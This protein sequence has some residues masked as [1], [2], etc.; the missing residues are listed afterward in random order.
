MWRQADKEM[1]NQK[2]DWYK[3]KQDNLKERVDIEREAIGLDK[4][5]MERELVKVEGKKY[6]VSD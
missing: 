2:I 4:A 3:S 6:A 5:A 1:L